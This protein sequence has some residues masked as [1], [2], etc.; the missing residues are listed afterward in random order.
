[1]PD[2]PDKTMWGVEQREWLKRGLLES[3]CHFKVLISPTPLI[4]PDRQ[5]KR[6][7]HANKNG[8]WTEGRQFLRWV[9]DSG[10]ADFYIICGDRHWQYHSIDEIGVEEFSCGST[11]D[12]HAARGQPHWGKDRQPHFRDGKGGFLMVEVLG[13]NSEPELRFTFLDV[14]GNPVYVC[15]KRHKA[16]E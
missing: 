2:G 12:K 11:S 1:M 14:D 10:L 3:R 16:R 8:F 9:K 7:N 6:D 4:G 15:R 5:A 13:S